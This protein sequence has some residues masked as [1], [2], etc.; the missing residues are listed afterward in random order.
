MADSI[1]HGVL[2]GYLPNAGEFE[3]EHYEGA[4]MLGRFADPLKGTLL[5][6]PKY[7]YT[8][9]GH[10]CRIVING[11]GCCIKMELNESPLDTGTPFNYPYAPQ[12]S[13]I[14]QDYINDHAG[15]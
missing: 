5:A 14:I 4:I 9:I 15:V 3:V 7:L 6:D 1:Y 11:D 10:H 8:L 12:H 2:L 13:R